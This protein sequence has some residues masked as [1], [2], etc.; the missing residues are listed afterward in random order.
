[1]ESNK[2]VHFFQY[3]K[4]LNP[5]VQAFLKSHSI[6]DV[7]TILLKGKK[8]DD[9]PATILAD[10]LRGRAVAKE[11]LPDLVANPSIIYPPGLNLEQS[12]SSATAALKAELLS[13]LVNTES[14]ADITGG[15]GIDA[16]HFSSR[17]RFV[18]YIEPNSLLANIA[19]HNHRALGATNIDHKATT[20]EAFL[21]DTGPKRSVIYADPSRRVNARRV[22]SLRD[23][24]PN[25]INLLPQILSRADAL[26]IKASPMLD[27]HHSVAELGRVSR[28]IVVS[29]NQECRELLFLCEKEPLAE[30][31]IATVHLNAAGREVF[32]FVP[33]EEKNAQVSF[34]GVNAFLYEPNPSILKAGAFKLVA[35]RFGLTKLGPNSHLY[36]SGSLVNDFPGRRFSVVSHLKSDPHSIARVL[37]E[38]KANVMVRNY[39][40]SADSLKKKLKVKDGG[41]HFIVGTTADK[42]PVLLLAERV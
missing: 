29:V 32:E 42:G 1:M 9:I 14:I 24:E 21:A 22:V 11:K 25:V 39:P 31:V 36:T 17:F 15:F 8:V 35:T 23:C 19:A 3:E 38:G 37:P 34:G 41:T 33:S 4:L 16:Y 10:Q 2:Q 12:S 7:H 20:A 28:V 26:M 40:L 6:A 5:T 30:P 27:I 18:E 13:Q